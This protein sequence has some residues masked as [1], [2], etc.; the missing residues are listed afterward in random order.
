MAAGVLCGTKIVGRE[1]NRPLRR[2][3]CRERVWYKQKALPRPNRLTPD[4]DGT[5]R[6]DRMR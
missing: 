5:M 6:Q 3:A 4:A 2:G 1:R